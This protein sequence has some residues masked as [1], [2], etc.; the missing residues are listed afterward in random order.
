[1]GKPEMA[2]QPL[3]L[4]RGPV[5]AEWIDYNGHMN[6]AY[7]V[8]AFDRA[9][10]KLF[11]RFDLGRDYV[12]RTNSS[13]FVMEMHVSYERELKRGDPLRISAQLIEADA[14]RLHLF[15]SMYHAESG[16]CAATIEM[17]LLHVDLGLRRSTPFPA[18]Q[19]AAIEQLLAEHRGLARPPQLG[20][21][22][23]IK[24]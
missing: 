19:R 1:M 12:E 5:Q 24:R 11:D 10:D 15:Q 20:R 9:T 14:K 23:G 4:Y 16:V 2:P 6:I 18:P 7:Y 22:I 21:V 8:V 13:A 3:D 17:L